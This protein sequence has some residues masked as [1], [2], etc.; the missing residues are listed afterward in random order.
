MRRWLSYAA[1]GL[2][3]TLLAALVATALV[4]GGSERAVWL[5]AAL[6]YGLQL[7]AFGMLLAVRDRPQ[8]FLAA[9]AGGILLRFGAVGVVAFWLARRPVLPPAELLLSLV[10]F[11][12]LLLLLEPV[13]LH[14]R[15]GGGAAP[16]GV[17]G[18]NE[19]AN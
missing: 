16:A 7:V 2:G 12:M 6:A 9:W 18:A 19:E 3:L 14:G 1:V 10:V 17:G 4:A 13:F 8:L 11:M 15:R 5:A